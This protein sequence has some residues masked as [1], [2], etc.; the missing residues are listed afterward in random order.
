MGKVIYVLRGEFIRKL[1][2]RI[3]MNCPHCGKPIDNHVIGVLMGSIKSKKKAAASRTNGKLGGRPR[4]V[5]YSPPGESV[6]DLEE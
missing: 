3:Y 6:R 1:K 4:K 5:I 2:R